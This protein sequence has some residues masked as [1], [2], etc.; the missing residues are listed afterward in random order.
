MFDGPLH[1]YASVGNDVHEGGNGKDV[2]SRY[3]N[4]V[5]RESMLAIVYGTESSYLC[6]N[7]IWVALGNH[8][9]DIVTSGSAGPQ[10]M[11]YSAWQSCIVREVWVDVDRIEVAE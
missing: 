3:E 11:C 4:V 7:S 9:L 6:K 2:T 1:S 10:T 5:A 8:I